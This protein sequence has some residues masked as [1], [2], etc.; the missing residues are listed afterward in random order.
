MAKRF[1]VDS[2]F[3][4]T[5]NYFLNKA[6]ADEYSGLSL[7]MNNGYFM[8]CVCGH[9]EGRTEGSYYSQCPSC[10]GLLWNHHVYRYNP[11]NVRRMFTTKK[12][13]NKIE[14]HEEELKIR[15]N[16]AFYEAVLTDTLA[17]YAKISPI[18]I[19]LVDVIGKHYGFKDNALQALLKTPELAE[20]SQIRSCFD[21]SMARS[22]NF[23]KA[24]TAINNCGIKDDYLKNPKLYNIFLNDLCR[25]GWHPMDIDTWFKTKGAKPFAVD[26]LK[27][28]PYDNSYSS[29]LEYVIKSLNSAEKVPYKDYFL[30][31][32]SR[33]VMSFSTF[34][35]IVDAYW[36]IRK[37]G[38]IPRYTVPSKGDK[39]LF[40]ERHGSQYSQEKLV[41]PKELAEDYILFCK[42]YSNR[43]WNVATEFF[44]R[45]NELKL[46]GKPL[47]FEN[48]L[49]KNFYAFANENRFGYSHIDNFVEE[50]RK[51]PLACLA[52]MK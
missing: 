1:N 52:K 26:I 30:E 4:D 36:E 48:L 5:I 20:Y 31:L 32:V 13:S 10:G 50:F 18:E 23:N 25:S 16:G 42:R 39:Y 17:G 24:I 22:D 49:D 27:K 38:R 28:I 34:A 11:F 8:T 12:S 19:K 15:E 45:V 44:Q 43:N 37:N 47:I 46:M 40:G 6:G 9:Q 21:Y 29:A 33:G 35:D 14:V 41:V 7:M 3:M 2:S 51:N